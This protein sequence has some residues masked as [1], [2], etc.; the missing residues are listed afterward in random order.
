MLS[1]LTLAY[2][3]EVTSALLGA[4]A[5]LRTPG[6]DEDAGLFVLNMGPHLPA[7]L[8][9]GLDAAE[10][11]F[12]ELQAAAARLPELDRQIYY[13]Q[14][15]GSTLAILGHRRH[16][17]SLAEQ[18]ERFLHVAAAPASDA[19][20]DG[21]RQ[22]IRS[23]LTAMGYDGDLAAQCAAWERNLLVEPGEVAAV[24]AD[25]LDQAWDRTAA[26]IEFPAPKADGMRVATVRGAHFNARSDYLARTIEINIDPALT[27]PALKHLAVHEGYPGHYL[28]F[29]LRQHWYQQGLA[30]ADGLLSLVNSASSCTFEGIAD[31]GLRWL[32]WI[33]S[34][35]DRL[36]AL[37]SRYRAGLGTA[38]AWRLH[39]LGWDATRTA[40]WLR[41]RALIGGE[42]WVANR[43]G[44]IA[45]PQR[46]ALITSYWQGEPSV[47]AAWGRMPGG[48]SS[49]AFV[50]FVYGRMHSPESILLFN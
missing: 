2:A 44:F 16:A 47:A 19:Q 27:R 6:G 17:L 37:L 32:D 35:D 41:E 5:L 20:L 49:D 4:D 48:R 7:T 15:C 13:R 24:I 29:K 3:E 22:E 14:L 42:G 33:D 39:A 43:M 23:R 18:I 11:C 34:D 9:S 31:C 1:D 8:F 30:P 21:M 10:A 50:R 12:R 45:A 38:A 25:L 26:R 40:D 46:C 36:S 28:Q